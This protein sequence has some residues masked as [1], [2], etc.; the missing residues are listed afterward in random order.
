[1]RTKLVF[2]SLAVAC[3]NTTCRPKDSPA[4]M[5]VWTPQ[6]GPPPAVFSSPQ[7]AAPERTLLI[8]G[9]I[10]RFAKQH[11]GVAAVEGGSSQTIEGLDGKIKYGKAKFQISPEVKPKFSETELNSLHQ[12]RFEFL[13]ELFRRNILPKK[14]KVLSE[15][16][17]IV[18]PDRSR[19][20][21]CY[22]IDVLNTEKLSVERY[23]ISKNFRVLKKT[24]V[25]TEFDSE[26][27][28]Y[29]IENSNQLKDVLLKN[30][31]EGPAVQ[32]TDIAVN[33]QAPQPATEKDAPWKFDIDDPRFDQ[34][35]AFYFVRL[36]IGFYARK[37]DFTI[38]TTVQVET[39]EG[40]PDK[41]NA[42]FT[43][44]NQIR[45]GSGDGV[46]YKNLAKD[47]SV[48]IHE[49]GHVV[50]WVIA[51]LP[52]QYEGGSINEGFADFFAA[53][54]LNDPCMGRLSYVPGPCTRN[55]TDFIPYPSKNGGLYHDSQIVSGT[56]WRIRN[57]LGAERTQKL[58]LQ[59][60]ER[61]GPATALTEFS[62]ALRLATAEGKAEEIAAV[63]AVLSS[64]QWPQ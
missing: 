3:V 13:A 10:L 49:L 15:P 51:H 42:A 20:A 2:L 41:V 56:L 63:N 43:Y 37:V 62:A 8:H 19:V 58:A 28:V 57:L 36:G 32:S 40:Y 12:R 31:I 22:G 35:Q 46:T 38:P 5:V 24:R 26:A 29:T 50:T 30:L 34:V 21:K 44:S 33:S 6:Q 25:S 27:L 59:T 45:I 60:L 23:L 18:W 48:V 9:E 17:V 39:S 55:L 16:E 61:L 47:P 52:T 11:W 53:S 54:Y 7:F 1:M 14:S 4:Q 64:Y